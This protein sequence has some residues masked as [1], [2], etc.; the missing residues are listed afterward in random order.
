VPVGG[1]EMAL[2]QPGLGTIG[3]YAV[4]DLIPRVRV[5]CPAAERPLEF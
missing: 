4:Y 5:R 3:E 1:Y 2:A